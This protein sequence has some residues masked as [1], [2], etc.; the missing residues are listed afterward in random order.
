VSLEVRYLE[1]L[2]TAISN[3]ISQLGGKCPVVIDPK[4]N[5]KSAARKI[6]WG[7]FSNAGQVSQSLSRKPQRHAILK[8]LQTCIAPDYVI[9]PK[10][11]QSELAAALEEVYVQHRD[12]GTHE[13]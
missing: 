2:H 11:F 5:V 8:K 1:C 9:V 7:K 10:H 12:L 4:C 13:N 6:L 3:R